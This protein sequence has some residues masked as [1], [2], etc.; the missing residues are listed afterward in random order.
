PP[1]ASVTFASDIFHAARPLQQPRIRI[2]R[3]HLLRMRTVT[4][5]HLFSPPR[6]TVSQSNVRP[7]RTSGRTGNYLIYSETIPFAV[8]LSNHERNYDT[9]SDGGNVRG[10]IRLNDRNISRSEGL[11]DEIVLTAVVNRLNSD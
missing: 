3:N 2:K 8:R 7:S 1:S 10:G 9:L 11:S 5:P 6:E 4:K